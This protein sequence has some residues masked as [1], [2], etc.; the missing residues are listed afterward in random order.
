MESAL[1][2]KES[3]QKEIRQLGQELEETKK[4]RADVPHHVKL[5]GLPQNERFDQ[6]SSGSKDLVETIKFIAYRAETAMFV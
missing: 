1:Q 6:L 2:K 3:L 4:R 5:G